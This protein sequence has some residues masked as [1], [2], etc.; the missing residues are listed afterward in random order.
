LFGSDYPFAPEATMA[1]SVKALREMGLE[2]DVL[3]GIERGH[4]LRLFPHL[5]AS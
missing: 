3:R 2:P 5:G 4:A 1:G